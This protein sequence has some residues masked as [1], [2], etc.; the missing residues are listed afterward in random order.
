MIIQLKVFEQTLSVVATNNAEQ[1][2]TRPIT[3]SGVHVI[4]GNV[5]ALLQEI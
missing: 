2:D 1:D 5:N 3:S 4:C